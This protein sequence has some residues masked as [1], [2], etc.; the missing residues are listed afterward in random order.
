VS[1]ADTPAAATPDPDI[2]E[3][4]DDIAK[5]TIAAAEVISRRLGWVET[6]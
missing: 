3:Q 1:S 6:P 4:F 2:P 5:R